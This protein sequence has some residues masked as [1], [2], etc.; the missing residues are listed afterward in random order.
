MSRR[1][2]RPTARRLTPVSHPTGCGSWWDWTDRVPHT[3]S[4]TQPR[5]PLAAAH[6]SLTRMVDRY[7]DLCSQGMGQRIAA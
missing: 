2:Y 3:M 7:E 6:L 5:E 4:I 1:A